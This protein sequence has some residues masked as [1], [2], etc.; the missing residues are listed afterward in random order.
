MAEPPT[1]SPEE[2]ALWDTWMQAQRLLTQ[3]LDRGL[4]RDCGIS[5]PEFSV[6][7]TLWQTPNHEL[8]VGELADSLT[9][10]KSRVSHLLTRMESRSLVTPVHAGAPGRRTGVTLT[11]KGRE[12]AQQALLVHA[13]NIRHLFFDTI[14]PEQVEVFREWGERMIDRMEPGSRF[15][16]EG[17]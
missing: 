15:T 5:K 8:R 17:R 3:E 12:V 13:G 10:E 2:W 16:G 9:W 7:I 1:L 11:P 14:T 4:Q 6:L